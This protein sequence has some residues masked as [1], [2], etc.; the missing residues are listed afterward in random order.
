[1][2]SQIT[3][4]EETDLFV[5]YPLIDQCCQGMKSQLYINNENMLKV[6]ISEKRETVN[7]I[8]NDL[9]NQKLE[10]YKTF[11]LDALLLDPQT[12]SNKAQEII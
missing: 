11:N 1:M 3:P 6:I 4:L 5:D 10:F 9:V 12:I 7:I 8:K 2:Y